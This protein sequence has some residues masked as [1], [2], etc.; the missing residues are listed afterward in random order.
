MRKSI[1]ETVPVNIVLKDGSP[2]Y[3][4]HDDMMKGA[5]RVNA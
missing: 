1:N 5:F 3:A 2:L 4:P